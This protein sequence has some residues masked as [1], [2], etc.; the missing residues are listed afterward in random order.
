[1]QRFGLFFKMNK[2]IIWVVNT[3]ES[4]SCKVYLRHEEIAY[5][6]SDLFRF[7]FFL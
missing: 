1:M 2:K 4:L 3:V 7:I 6:L 5:N